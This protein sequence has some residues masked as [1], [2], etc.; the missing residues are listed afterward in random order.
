MAGLK[1]MAFVLCLL[2]GVHSQA[3]GQARS[4][5]AR[6]ELLYTAHCLTC[7]TSEIHW[8]EQKLATGWSSLKALVRRWQASIGL[9]WSE[10]EIMDVVRYLNAAYYG[11]MDTDQ[12]DLSQRTKPGQG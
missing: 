5:E 3:Y 1:K 10:E 11:F 2:W 9:A 12:K 8:R 6:G 7:H 4:G